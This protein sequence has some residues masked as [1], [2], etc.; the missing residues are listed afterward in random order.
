MCAVGRTK[1]APDSL[2]VPCDASSTL[3]DFPAF[4]AAAFRFSSVDF[5]ASRGSL[6]DFQLSSLYFDFKRLQKLTM[7]YFVIVVLVGLWLAPGNV[8]AQDYAVTVTG[9]T[10]RGTIKTIAYGAEKKVQITGTDKKKTA[11]PFTRVRLFSQKGEIYQ[12][13]KGPQGYVFMKLLKP[14]YASLYAFQLENQT[15]Y[16]GRFVAKR[17]GEGVEVPNLSFKKIMGRFFADCEAVAQKIEDGVLAKK[18]L[19]VIL[20]EYNQ[21]VDN[22]IT[23]REQIVAT[24]NETVKKISAWDVLEDKVKAEADFDGKTSALEMISDIKSKISRSE[25]VPNFLVSGLK[26]TITQPALQADLETALKELN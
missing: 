26:S 20:D 16:D 12:P 9:D 6:S 8:W 3:S 25:K 13:V 14:G 7:K 17:T 21:C 22:R 23:E 1:L 24:R 11:V 19:E 4:D 10:L 2:H 5:P 15:L 18:D